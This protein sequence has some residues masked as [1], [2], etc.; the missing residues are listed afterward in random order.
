MKDCQEI[1]IENGGEL[2]KRFES[3]NSFESFFYDFYYYDIEEDQIRNYR[4]NSDDFLSTFKHLS[5][6]YA[7]NASQPSKKRL[8][9]ESDSFTPLAIRQYEAKETK[10]ESNLSIEDR[11][12]IKTT[13]LSK[14]DKKKSKKAWKKGQTTE[15][16]IPKTRVYNTTDYESK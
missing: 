5:L 11:F 9:D 15:E 16:E 12:K 14:K 10:G 3:L 7:K 13:E 1:S 4:D 8:N 6:N 2:L